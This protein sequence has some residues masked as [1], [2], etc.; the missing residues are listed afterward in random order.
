MVLP[1]ASLVWEPEF[2]DVEESGDLG[3]TYGSFVFTAK[4]STGNDI[5]SK[6]VFHTVWKRQADGEWRF[7]WD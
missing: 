2:V 3:Y 4:D 1:D 7:V 6:G 5:E